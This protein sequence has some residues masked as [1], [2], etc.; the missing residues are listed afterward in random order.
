MLGRD[1]EKAVLVLDQHRWVEEQ[2]V[3]GAVELGQLHAQRHDDADGLLEV[4]LRPTRPQLF[5]AGA[6]GTGSDR[7][8]NREGRDQM[9]SAR[10]YRA[11]D[12][13]APPGRFL[14]RLS[15]GPAGASP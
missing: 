13:S 9:L 10:H 14:A 15:R 2:L 8:A 1:L 4:Q 11:A 5:E 12:A 6:Q 7:G 3:S